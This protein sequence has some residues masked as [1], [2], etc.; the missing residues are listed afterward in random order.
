MTFDSDLDLQVW[1]VVRREVIRQI[2]AGQ[3]KLVGMMVESN[4]KPGK[5]A[6]KEGGGLKLAHG[7]S[8]TDACIG[9]DETQSLL[10][11]AAEAVRTR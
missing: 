7:V 8:I 3:T 2:K 9:W 5:Q 11:E 10:L 1:D 6:W 4:L